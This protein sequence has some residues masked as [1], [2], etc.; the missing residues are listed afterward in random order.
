MFRTGAA[1]SEAIE[2]MIEAETDRI[3]ANPLLLAALDVALT[4]LSLAADRIEGV[5]TTEDNRY[6]RAF[7]QLLALATGMY[8]LPDTEHTTQQATAVLLGAR[9]GARFAERARQE[10]VS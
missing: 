8:C 3:L 6:A 10:G 4:E 5:L 2:Q 9:L 1:R 7:P